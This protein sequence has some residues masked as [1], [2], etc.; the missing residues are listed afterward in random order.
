M[1][2]Q[3]HLGQHE[4]S[5]LGVEASGALLGAD[6]LLTGLDSC[7]VDMLAALGAD[8]KALGLPECYF[9]TGGHS[10]VPSIESLS[11]PGSG[12]RGVS[13]SMLSSR[14]LGEHTGACKKE[15]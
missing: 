7:R 11:P 15:V 6:L 14:V 2:S 1:E 10:T 12:R 4:T 5:P 13:G 3:K 9:D 8:R